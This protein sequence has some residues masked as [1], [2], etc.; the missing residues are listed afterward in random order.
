MGFV[1]WQAGKGDLG[2]RFGGTSH[3]I[4]LL[5]PLLLLTLHTPMNS[6]GWEGM[7]LHSLEDAC[8]SV[9]KTL[10]H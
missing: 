5:L 1:A 9:L 4:V 7:A 3:N 2:G 8:L 10:L 6:W